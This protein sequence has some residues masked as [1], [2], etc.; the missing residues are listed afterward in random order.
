MVDRYAV[1]HSAHPGAL[2]DGRVILRM[3]DAEFERPFMLL[4]EEPPESEVE[5]RNGEF[6]CEWALFP[7]GIVEG[8]YIMNRV[9]A[10][11]GRLRDMDVGR[12]P[13]VTVITPVEIPLAT[14]RARVRRA[15]GENRKEKERGNTRKL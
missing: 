3:V 10:V 6:V 15:A 9:F 13:K 7:L 5:L 8:L 4:F 2:I 11:E 12:R 14:R 1:L